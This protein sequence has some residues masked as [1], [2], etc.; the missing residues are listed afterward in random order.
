MIARFLAPAATMLALACPTVAT[1]APEEIQVYMDE[2]GA[3]GEIGLDV[4]NSYVLSGDKT[5]AYPG[6]QQSVH[7]YRITPEFSLGLSRAFELG[8]YLPLA[9]ID[10]GGA[11]RIQGVKLRLKYLVP[12]PADS[13][14]FYGLNFE[15]GRV[16]HSLDANPYNAELKGIAGT[17]QGKWTL[18]ANLNFDF[19]VSGPAP[20]PASLE[21]ATKANFAVT[22]KFALGIEN[23]T[24]LGEVR[25]LG[26]FGSSEQTTYVT[27][28]TSIGKWDLNL[29]V[30]RGYGANPDRW[31]VKAIVG[32]PFR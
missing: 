28:D 21:L 26:R 15:I 5:P 27:A 18:A 3:P 13:H 12:R 11:F 16:G 9:T 8:A 1:A 2:M 14:W 19:K 17:H 20:A 4:H 30:G 22:P 25:G 7:R 10:H 6:E 29:G 31:I 23:Y 32:V 24:G